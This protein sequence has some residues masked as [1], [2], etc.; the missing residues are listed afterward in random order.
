VRSLAKALLFLFAAFA[1]SAFHFGERENETLT[2]SDSDF[3]L[4]MAQVFSGQKPE[5]N[6]HFFEIAS[7][8]YNRPLLP[9][10]AAA[11]GRGIL[12]GD[13]RTAFSI[14]NILF[15]ALS[16]VLLS[17]HLG[18]NEETARWDVLL[19]LLFLFAFPQLNW[20]YHILT[21]TTGIALAFLA[22]SMSVY[23]LERRLAGLQGK[24]FAL[25]LSLIFVIESLAFLAR[26]SGWFAPIAVFSAA[27]LMNRRD[28][29]FPAVSICV[30]C[31]A[32]KF[33]HE[34]FSSWAGTH[35][36]AFHF[37][38]AIIFNPWYLLDLAVK[39]AVAFNLLWLCAL[40]VKWRQIPVFYIAWSAAALAYMAAGYLHNDPRAI[41][42]PLRM[43]FSLFPI[44]F[45]LAGRAFSASE[46]FRGRLSRVYVFSAA[47]V[48][49]NIAGVFLDHHRGAI[50]I[51][52]IIGWG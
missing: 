47:F 15:A 16:A 34:L 42:Y 49:L 30:V 25:W 33:P 35:T 7:H 4:D 11:V 39:S 36:V 14:V 38:P 19:P 31:I 45:F 5:W 22:S 41:G 24:F 21:D 29:F 1:A 50:T 2:L 23:L 9:A 10:A 32:A 28:A 43:T 52:S 17:L 37:D 18:R 44:V 40:L 3:Y 26:E 46:L 6:P 48:A 12:G 13:F 20:G 27:Y 8:H 51:K